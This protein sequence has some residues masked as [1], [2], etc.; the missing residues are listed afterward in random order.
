MTKISYKF[1][2]TFIGIIAIY[3][4]LSA[5]QE[6]HKHPEESAVIYKARFVDSG[7]QQNKN[8]SDEGIDQ[9]ESMIQPLFTVLPQ[10]INIS[11]FGDIYSQFGY[12]GEGE[13][14]RQIGQME[15]DLLMKI[16]EQVVLAIAIAYV[17]DTETFGLGQFTVDI[18]LFDVDDKYLFNMKSIDRAG[19]IVGLFDVLFGIDWNVYLSIDRKLISIPLAVELTHNGWNDYSIQLYA[20]NTRFNGVLFVTNGFDFEIEDEDGLPLLLNEQSS[21]GGR[22]GVKSFETLEIEVSYSK[23]FNHEFNG[24]LYGTD[25]QFDFNNITLKGENIAHTV[26]PLFYKSNG[27]YFQGIYN[28]NQFFLVARYDQFSINSLER[29]ENTQGSLGAGWMIFNGFEIRYENQLLL[30][31]NKNTSFLQLVVGF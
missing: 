5:A 17:L 24:S 30:H 16:S 13:N 26:N 29:R 4:S 21:I 11:G 19:I 23:I 20:E 1:L 10:S 7:D 9:T 15:I 18:P 27:F 28:F 6:A 14:N 25:I 2:P 8:D 22:L 31:K 3:F 12:K